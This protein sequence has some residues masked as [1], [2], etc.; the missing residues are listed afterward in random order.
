MATIPTLES[1]STFPGGSLF[2]RGGQGQNAAG[3]TERG[4]SW[5]VQTALLP[6]AT[7]TRVRCSAAILQSTSNSKVTSAPTPQELI[8]LYAQSTVFPPVIAQA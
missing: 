1:L 7:G 3:S 8:S 4:T 5:V 6:A 2:R